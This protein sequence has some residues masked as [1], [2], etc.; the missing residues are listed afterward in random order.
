MDQQTSIVHEI[1]PG[2]VFAP[3]P[4]WVEQDLIN[5]G[6]PI[7]PHFISGGLC[8]L[9]DDTQID[10]C[11][12]E[13]A[14]FRRRAFAVTAPGAAE[15]VAQF[16][17]TYD[18]RYERLEIHAVRVLRGAEVF[19]YA[20]R[21]GFESLRREQNLERLVFD[22]R[23]TI[24]FTIPDV[25][26]GDIVETAYTR[27]GMRKT[28]HGRHAAW[29]AFDWSAPIV[30]AR[31]RQRAPR[32]REIA[33]RRYNEPPTAE[34]RIEGDIVDRRW[35]RR[36]AQAFRYE[37]LTPPAVLQGS[38]IQWSEWR[39][40][41]EVA[42]NFLPLYND[43]D[44]LPEAFEQEVQ[45]L[46]QEPS[47]SARAAALLRF[48]QGTVRYLAVAIGEGGYTPRPL[49]DIG[50]T[51]YGDC[52]D[53]SK[54]YVSMARRLGLNA[55]PA[56]VNTGDGAVLDKCLPSAEL[57]DHCVVRVEVDG[58]VYWLDPTRNVQP[59][60]LPAL[61]QVHCVW[62]L[63]LRADSAGL[64]R[65][66][67]WPLTLL[68]ETNE[69]ITLGKGPRVPVQYEWEQKLR[70][71]RADV[72]REQFVREGEIGVFKSYLEDIQKKWPEA[73][74]IT[75]TMTDDVATNTVTVIEKYELPDAWSKS[76]EDTRRHFQTRDLTIRGTLAPLDIGGR[77]HDIYLGIPS[78][79]VR[80]VDVKTATRHN[81]A[82]S[83]RTYAE[84]MTF[85]D[86]LRVIEPRWLVLEQ[87]LEIRKS[88]LP[89][90]YAGTYAQ[91]VQQ[92]NNNELAIA[93]EVAGE[94]F[95]DGGRKS[96]GLGAVN[97]VRL[98]ILAFV[99][100]SAVARC[101]ASQ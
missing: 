31:H 28:L 54:L 6:A 30:E 86:D 48:V 35:R 10:L 18:P 100:L 92:M 99:V 82:W 75:Q 49:A 59:N 8:A 65:M 26:A 72:T 62:A 70:G 2:A 38:S 19:E 73:R 74:I 22:G 9:L 93:L 71:V 88:V 39:D 44:P 47:A 85:T 11:G 37:A 23:Q 87:I 3:T 15:R 58:K 33:E 66:P 69:R 90:A 7:D 36:D 68:T 76:N 55:C 63:P 80:R 97:T 101:V 56:L 78:R 32:G 21:A 51:R 14:W 46:A 42:Q 17:T 16:N 25:R 4:P 53:K 79:R 43:A 96:G 41:R 20:G 94:K 24:L 27:Y 98:I 13:R 57:F 77:K 34:E 95:K 50:A 29:M 45:K 1:A 12:E 89:A 40:W 52:K 83:R 61:T 60:P 84:A 64:E 67:D 81:G 5:T 91:A